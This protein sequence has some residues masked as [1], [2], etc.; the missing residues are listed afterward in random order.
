MQHRV[1]DTDRDVLFREARIH[2]AWLDRPVSD[3]TLREIY[4]LMKWAPTS[5]NSSP[6]AHRVLP[7]AAGQGAAAAG[8]GGRERPEQDD[9][10]RDRHHGDASKLFP[11]S[12]RLSFEEACT[13]L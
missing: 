1:D 10:A 5:A 2:S 9:G 8:A 11:R 4:D 6:R 13:L 12:P 7:D 3:E